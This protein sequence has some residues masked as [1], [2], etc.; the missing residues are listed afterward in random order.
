MTFPWL[1]VLGLLPIVGGL[2]LLLPMGKGA[3]RGLGMFFALLTAVFG[4]VVAVLHV[5]GAALAE[6]LLALHAT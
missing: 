1:T 3:A 6:S 5:G 4:V 2:A